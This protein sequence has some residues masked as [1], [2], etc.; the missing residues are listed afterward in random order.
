VQ[1][2][3]SADHIHHAALQV[4]SI[5]LVVAAI[6]WWWAWCGSSQRGHSGRHASV[7][8]TE[9]S[10]IRSRAGGREVRRDRKL[11]PWGTSRTKK[12][13]QSLSA[14]SPSLRGWIYLQWFY[15]YC[16]GSGLNLKASAFYAMRI[17]GD[18]GLLSAGGTISDRLT[19]F[20][21]SDWRCYLARS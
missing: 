11:L 3:A 13:L 9:L 21:S 2:F 16:A 20:M 5:F 10:F 8:P 1:A 4:E 14:I 17:S 18:G 7:S 19:R 12:C 6:G 15:I